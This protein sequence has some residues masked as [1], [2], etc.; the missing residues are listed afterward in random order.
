MRGRRTGHMVTLCHSV[1]RLNVRFELHEG[2]IPGRDSCWALRHAVDFT[3]IFLS[4]S[5][6]FML[7][8]MSSMFLSSRFTPRQE[9]CTIGFFKIIVTTCFNATALIIFA[10]EQV[11]V[12]CKVTRIFSTA[13]DDNGSDGRQVVVG[14]A[15]LAGSFYLFSAEESFPVSFEHFTRQCQQNQDSREKFRNSKP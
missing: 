1:G 12:R 2:P 4:T 10:I 8:L 3:N 7:S 13:Q 15:P 6:R 11:H 9:E 14:S 5:Y